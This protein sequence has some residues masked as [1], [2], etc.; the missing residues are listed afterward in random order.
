[1]QP[2]P[3][4]IRDYGAREGPRDVERE[5]A[6]FEDIRVGLDAVRRVHAPSGHGSDHE[7]AE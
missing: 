5:F 3:D 2:L 1:M 6:E 4:I 7:D